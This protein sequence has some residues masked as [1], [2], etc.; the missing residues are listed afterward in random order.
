MAIEATGEMAGAPGGA[1]LTNA[2]QEL[3][4]NEYAHLKRLVKDAGLL[5]K[6]PGHYA[7]KMAVSISLL[8]LSVTVL[9]L[10]DGVWPQMLNAA[11]L[12]FIIVQMSFIGHDLGHKQVF[13]SSRNNDILGLFVSFLVGINLTWW[14]EKH[15]EHHSNPNDL[16]MDPD[17][18]LPVVAFS[19]DQA[20]DMTGVARLIVRYQ[21]FLFYPLV[22][23]EGFVLKFSG[24]RFMFTNRL[25][26]PIAEPIMM[27]GHIGVYIG[28][29]FLSLPFWQGLLFIAVNQLLLG[30]YIGSTFAPNHKGMLMLDGKHQLDFLR[31]QVLTS[32]NV[33][34]SPANDLLYGGLNYQIEH[35]LFPSMP[36]N[37]LKEA[38]EIVR[39][40]C[41]E[42]SISYYE[43]GV[44]QSQREILQYLHQVSAPLRA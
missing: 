19:E 21:A 28:L 23:F 42:H 40:F 9:T 17:I 39:P 10:V 13:R 18:E 6:N 30:L 3:E 31:R 8:A 33:K 34:S 11:F 26:F 20:R 37:R 14:V 2:T 43:T 36:R 35:H 29:V 4:S 22:C 12:A 24:I 38:Q 32:R 25:K 16:D 27:A 1:P 15:N 5:E 44:I 7:V 41:R